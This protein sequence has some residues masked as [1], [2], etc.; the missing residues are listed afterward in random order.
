[1]MPSFLRQ[2]F[3]PSWILRFRAAIVW[4]AQDYWKDGSSAAPQKGAPEPR[5][6]APQETQASRPKK[7]AAL[8]SADAV[9]VKEKIWGYG[10]VLSNAEALADK[11]S[12]PLGLDS[13][14]TVLDMA[15]GLGGQARKIA[16]GYGSYVTGLEPD[17]VLAERGMA[18]SIASGKGKHATIESYD[19]ALFL[20][21]KRYDCIVSRELFY[22]VANKPRFFKSMAGSLKPT[23]QLAFFDYI[24][25]PEARA[26]PAVKAWLEH[27]TGADPMPLP[28]MLQAWSKLGLEIRVNED[29]TNEFRLGITREL[30]A[31]A[32]FLARKPPDDDTK[33][34]VAKEI[35]L[36]AHR[37][38][39][40]GEGLKFY[41]F[42][43]I[44]N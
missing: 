5:Q 14:K 29:M 41:R 24:L 12:A 8:W 31:F 23:C 21:E 2:N 43:A 35:D 28:L 13:L 37:A 11:L 1:M 38:A 40:M 4:L 6:T 17:P 26:K 39:A 30:T 19:P 9:Q 3:T 7:N 34:L 16:E 32:A 15:A 22:R 44:R 33:H 25:A 36:W 42:Y 27:E 18:L 20:P 10:N